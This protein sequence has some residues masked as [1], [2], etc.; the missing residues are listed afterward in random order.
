M[1]ASASTDPGLPRPEP[2]DRGGR[3]TFD[4]TIA[5]IR[6]LRRAQIPFHVISVLSS[7]SMSAPREM[8]DFYVKEGIKE[9]CFNVEESEGAM[10]PGPSRMQELKRHTTSS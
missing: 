6:P 3:G 8:F 2:V 1:S 10:F 4:K 5:G 9:V 7:R